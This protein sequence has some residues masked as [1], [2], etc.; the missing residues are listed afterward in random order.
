MALEGPTT[1][2]NSTLKMT[3]IAKITF[4]GSGNSGVV[5]AARNSGEIR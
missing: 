5:R 3:V 2:A 1:E 4:I